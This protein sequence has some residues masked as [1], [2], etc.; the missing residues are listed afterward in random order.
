[1]GDHVFLRLTVLTQ[2]VK[3]NSTGNAQAMLKESV[4]PSYTYINI[5]LN[6]NV[7]FDLLG[8]KGLTIYPFVDHRR[9]FIGLQVIGRFKKIT[10]V[11]ARSD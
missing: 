11:S 7:T 6:A 5:I 2:S 4:K 1:M 9:S 8:L 3:V 10:A